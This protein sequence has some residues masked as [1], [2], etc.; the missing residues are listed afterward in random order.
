MAKYDYGSAVTGAASGAAVGSAFGPIGTAGGAIL[1]G[2]TGL[3]GSKKKKAKKRSTLDPQTQA[4][5]DDY[6]SGLRGEG[7]FADLY[8]FDAEG[9]NDV[10]D[11][12]IGRQAYRNFNENIVPTITGQFRKKN[13]GN[14][15]YTGETLSRA[16]R[17]VQE[18]LD[19]QR[20]QN[21]FNGQQQAKQNKINGIQNAFNVNTFDYEKPEQGGIDKIL[22]SLG[23]V[24]AEYLVNTLK[25]KTAQPTV[26]KTP[27]TTAPGAY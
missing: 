2:L 25:P 27:T 11:K 24:A 5:Y 8:N 15:S 21:V 7:Q 20:S 1:G 16:G 14:S 17:D 23:P 4:L 9:Y 26:P 6:I 19:A 22:N 18:S 3:F 12:T 13:I 10:F